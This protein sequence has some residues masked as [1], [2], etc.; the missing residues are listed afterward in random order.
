MKERPLS[1]PTPF[2]LF[3]TLLNQGLVRKVLIFKLSGDGLKCLVKPEWKYFNTHIG[4]T[5]GS[6]NTFVIPTVVV[7]G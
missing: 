7:T 2:P 1:P 3:L 5:L 6:C 4:G